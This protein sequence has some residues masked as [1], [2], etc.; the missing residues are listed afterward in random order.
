V[1]DRPPTWW[2]E[3]HTP[4]LAEGARRID[5]HNY[6]KEKQMQDTQKIVYKYDLMHRNTPKFARTT[7]QWDTKLLTP[8][9]RKRVIQSLKQGF[10]GYGHGDAG[11]MYKALVDKFEV[12]D[13]LVP[14]DGENGELRFC[15]V[16]DYVWEEADKL[17]KADQ[18]ITRL[19]GT[20][21][22]WYYDSP[23]SREHRRAYLRNAGHDFTGFKQ[24]CERMMKEDIIAK[25][26]RD[27]LLFVEDGGVITFTYNPTDR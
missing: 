19:S 10:N 18:V 16:P 13:V 15:H 7:V 4:W 14:K 5:R 9:T 20:A 22:S 21:P 27:A 17:H 26:L 12:P 8:L 11:Q 25:R 23:L 3:K 1:N 2:I 6:Q 24:A